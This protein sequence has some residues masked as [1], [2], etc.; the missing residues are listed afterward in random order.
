M[1][2]GAKCATRLKEGNKLGILGVLLE[3]RGK[4]QLFFFELVGKRRDHRRPSEVRIF[5]FHHSNVVSLP[6]Q[7]NLTSD[8]FFFFLRKQLLTDLSDL[9]HWYSQHSAAKK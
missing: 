6:L 8:T 1:T 9:V 4:S 7:S 2:S 5:P 3:D